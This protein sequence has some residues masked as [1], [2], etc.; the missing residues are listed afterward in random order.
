MDAS[1]FW[2]ESGIQA[3]LSS[4]FTSYDC[5]TSSR[6]TSSSPSTAN[7]DTVLL[8]AWGITQRLPAYEDTAVE[9]TP[10]APGEYEFTC[11]MS[12]LHGRLVAE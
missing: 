9:F 4:T 11:G 5:R 6:R 10:V 7:T 12:M 8:P 1:S 2:G 3:V